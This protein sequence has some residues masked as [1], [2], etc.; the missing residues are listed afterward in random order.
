[1]NR[2]IEQTLLSL[3]PTHNSALPQPLTD[4]ASSLL[5]QSRNRA[6]TLKA[7]EEVARLYACAHL[8]CDRLKVALDLPPIEPRPPIPPRIYKRLYNHLDKILPASA[9]TPGRHTPSGTPLGSGRIRTPSAKIREQQQQQQQQQLLLNGSPLA[10]KSR[11]TPSKER[12]LSDLRAR[13]GAAATPSKDRTLSSAGGGGGGPPKQRRDDALPPWIRPALR[14]LLTK[15]GPAHIGPVVASGLES[16]VAPRGRLTDD[17]WVRAHLVAVLG[18]LY[19]FVWRGVVWPAGREVERERGWEGWEEPSVRE[20][21]AAAV[22]G[23]RHGW[24]DMD[25]VDG[26]RDLADREEDKRRRAEGGDDGGEGE[27]EEVV[28]TQIRRPDTMFQ[29]R[30]DYL[31]ERKRK[32]YAEWKEGLLKRIK[33]LEAR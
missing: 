23:A 29:E 4:L 12:S 21:D 22:R 32:A 1:M 24:F 26:V 28:V 33:E 25:W 6:S 18:A 13:A 2:S 11:T 5:A 31:S 19:L 14:Y 10:S 17:G 15:L 3:L 30:Y 8:A 16:V 27:G 9:S 7:E 20:F